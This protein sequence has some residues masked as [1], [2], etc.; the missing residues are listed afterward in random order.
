MRYEVFL[1][2]TAEK[3]LVFFKKNGDKAQLRKIEKLLEELELH[4]TTGTGKPELLKGA[5][6]GCYSRRIDGKNRMIY[7]IDN[8]KVIVD[9]LSV[10]GHYA[11]K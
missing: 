10:K 6:S 3:Q 8:E 11:D 5:L 4:P 2:Q 7:S 1:S 9:V